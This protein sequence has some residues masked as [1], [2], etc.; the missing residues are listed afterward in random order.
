MTSAKGG[1]RR[2]VWVGARGSQCGWQLCASPPSSP[3]RALLVKTSPPTH[4]EAL[5]IDDHF[6]VG[7]FLRPSAVIQDSPV[8]EAS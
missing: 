7:D 2:V 8:Q 6:L 5:V 4:G 1:V 3:A